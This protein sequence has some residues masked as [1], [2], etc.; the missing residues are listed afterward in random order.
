MMLAET[1]G[2]KRER[3]GKTRD[4]DDDGR[5]RDRERQNDG[6]DDLQAPHFA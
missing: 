4:D 5:Q 2:T 6:N 3:T 1:R